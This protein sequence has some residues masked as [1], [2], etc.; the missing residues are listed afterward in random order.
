MHGSITFCLHVEQ[1]HW[2]KVLDFQIYIK[3]VHYTIVYVVFTKSGWA[4]TNV[5]LLY[6]FGDIDFFYKYTDKT[7]GA[8]MALGREPYLRI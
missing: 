7:R 4:H 6:Y 5:K 2:K 3:S 1:N 8:K